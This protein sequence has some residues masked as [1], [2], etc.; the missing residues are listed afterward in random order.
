MSK[1]FQEKAFN[2]NIK[3]KTSPTNFKYVQ[4][5]RELRDSENYQQAFLLGVLNEFCSFNIKLPRKKTTVTS[6]FHVLV[7]LTFNNEKLDILKI[8][9]THCKPKYEFDIKGGMNSAAAFRRYDKNKRVFT[10]NLLIDICVEVGYFFNSILA[11]KSKK[12]LRREVIENI[13]FGD[14]FLYNLNEIQT[15]GKCLNDYFSSFIQK[16]KIYTI[17][18]NDPIVNKLVT[19]SKY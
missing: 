10:Q 3:E 19:K 9:E 8:I 18:R 5:K 2:K 11:R 16:K 1:I 7:N 4:N 14:I 17:S 6:S 15:R 12:N 13:F